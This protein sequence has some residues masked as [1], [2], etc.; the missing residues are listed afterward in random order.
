LT[1]IHKRLEDRN[2]AYWWAQPIVWKLNRDVEVAMQERFG[3]LT[4]QDMSLGQPETRGC[5]RSSM[6]PLKRSERGLHY[7][8]DTL[9]IAKVELTI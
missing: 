2:I 3:Q 4:G 7:I 9:W 8:P 1:I 5:K 6:A